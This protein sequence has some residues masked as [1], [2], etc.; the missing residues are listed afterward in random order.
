GKLFDS[1]IQKATELGV[2]RIVPLLTERTVS[3]IESGEKEQKLE[4]WNQVAIE[5]IKQCGS[6]WLPKIEMPCTIKE[7]LEIQSKIDLRMVGSLENERRH[8]RKCFEEFARKNGKLP[9][10]ISVAI[11]PE[12]DFTPEELQVLKLAGAQPITLG[13]LV[14]RTETAAM[15][16][17]SIINYETQSA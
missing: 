14:L 5:S 9:H 10:S 4:K 15:Y 7:F 8:P 1:I 2:W 16:C 12:G 3:K 6:P 11:G 17:L 13:N